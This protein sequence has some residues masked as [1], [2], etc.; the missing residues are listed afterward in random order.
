MKTETGCLITD[1][2]FETAGGASVGFGGGRK[3][4]AGERCVASTFPEKREW[5]EEKEPRLE[6]ASAS[7]IDGLVGA[8]GGLFRGSRALSSVACSSST[9]SSSP[10]PTRFTTG[11]SLSV[12]PLYQKHC[13]NS[14]IS[15]TV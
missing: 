4:V 10:P 7:A 12:N 6:V 5:R 3:G 13:P 14:T 8:F 2:V 11:V 1:L 9:A 15:A